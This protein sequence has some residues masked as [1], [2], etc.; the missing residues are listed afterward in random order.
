ML[1]FLRKGTKAPTHIHVSSCVGF[2]WVRG[3]RT[4]PIDIGLLVLDFL[5]KGTKAPTHIHV[6]SCVGVFR[7]RGIR[8]LSY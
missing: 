8:D 3:I 2:F 4:S 1:D 5:R 7:V 6:S